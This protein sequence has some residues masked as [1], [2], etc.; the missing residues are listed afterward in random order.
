MSKSKKDIN[1]EVMFYKLMP[2]G[3]NKC[4]VAPNVKKAQPYDPFSKEND[5]KTD[6]EKIS[7]SETIQ[8]DLSISNDSVALH[9]P[10]K[11]MCSEMTD[12]TI[13]VINI[14]EKMV[15]QRI[16]DALKKFNCCS[17][18]LCKQEVTMNALN[19][20]QPKYI[21]VAKHDIEKIMQNMDYSDVTQAIMKA[22]LKVKA[23]PHH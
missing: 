22:I 20:L 16:D 10:D 9:C 21:I 5:K 3:V 8:S 15:D 1:K 18:S 4:S 14:Y 17:C 13:I 12:N 2:T 23:N 19:N 6:D 11:S 7:E